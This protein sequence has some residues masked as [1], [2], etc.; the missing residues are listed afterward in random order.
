MRGRRAFSLQMLMVVYNTGCVC[1]S[2]YMFT[3]VAVE[4]IF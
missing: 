4:L 1:L 2:I 3:E